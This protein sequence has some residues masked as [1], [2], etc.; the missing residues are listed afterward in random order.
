MWQELYESEL[1]P[2]GIA[3]VTVALDT[4]GPDA[5]RPFVDRAE[6]THPS[7]LDQAHVLDEQLGI[8]NVPS[9]VWIDESGTIVRPPEPAHAP[10]DQ[11]ARIERLLERDDLPPRAREMAEETLGIRYEPDAYL[12]ALRDWA[13]NGADSS[14]VLSPDEVVERSRPIT[15]KVAEAAA[16]FELG[17]HL[18]RED[19]PEAAARWF[20]EAHRLDPDNWTYKRQAWQFVDPILQGPS[21]HYDSDWLSEV[22]RIGAEN[23][24]PPLELEPSSD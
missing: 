16:A 12:D 20:R 11:L 13:A 9:G 2:A 23:Y 14:Y 4:G 17:Q 6:P 3:V 22:R 5:A 24:Y 8:V 15:P 10:N 18:H 7:L 1:G 19:R 21:E